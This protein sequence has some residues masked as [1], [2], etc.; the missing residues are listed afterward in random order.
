[1]VAVRPKPS[2]NEYETWCQEG[3]ASPGA[4]APYGG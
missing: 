4:A 2:W 1:M 3:V